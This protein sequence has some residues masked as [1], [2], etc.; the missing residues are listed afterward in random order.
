[1]ATKIIGNTFISGALDGGGSGHILTYNTQSGAL[2]YTASSAIGG[3]GGSAAGSQY[4]VQ[5]N[6]NGAGTFGG[7]STFTYDATL[8]TLA[9]ARSSEISA[10]SQC[11]L[12]IGQNLSAKGINSIV[13]GDD[14]STN[15]TNCFAGGYDAQANSYSS[16]AFGIGVRAAG[17]ASAAFGISNIVSGSAS[18]AA[19]DNNTIL[20]N[21]TIVV[22]SG[23]TVAAQASA[24]FGST[25]T[26]I[27]GLNNL[28]VGN[29]N[30]STADSRNSLVVGQGNGVTNA[31]SA[32]IGV[33]NQNSGSGTLVVGSGNRMVNTA[34]LAIGT[35][36]FSTQANSFLI[37]FNLSASRQ[38]QSFVGK[39][40]N[41]TSTPDGAPDGLLFG[42]GG[43]TT[44]TRKTVFA[45]T[46]DQDGSGSMRIPHNTTDPAGAQNTLTTGSMY[47]D[48]TLNRIRIWNGSAWRTIATT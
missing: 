38:Y 1:M 40:N 19:G 26:S 36:N 23:N 15:N 48:I 27:E 44:V 34:A 5:Y 13:M 30:I 20:G 42:V 45:I 12:A 31:Y 24:V 28:V 25:N 41:A 18:I 4:S 33:D 22:G 39:Y 37:G 43:G 21:S 46:V 3:G 6:A 7:D 47:Y 9:V 16:I 8:L 35:S 29:T 32:T 11:S 2:T 10:P 17:S 14:C